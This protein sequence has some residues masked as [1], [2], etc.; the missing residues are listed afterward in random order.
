MRNIVEDGQPSNLP[1]PR[2][3]CTASLTCATSCTAAL[4]TTLLSRY[5]FNAATCSGASPL[6]A[7]RLR[8]NATHTCTYGG[9]SR[10]TS[11]IA[12]STLSEHGTTYVLNTVAVSSLS[13]AALIRDREGST[14]TRRRVTSRSFSPF[15]HRL[16]HRFD[17][18]CSASD[19]CP[20]KASRS[21]S[22]FENVAQ[23]F[24]EM[25]LKL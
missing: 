7:A 24:S 12:S 17:G 1:C 22:F 14:S 19:A 3:S 11:A 6:V 25:L 15:R 10:P 8:K 20:R 4:F 13:S 23:M 18:P 2:L 21:P 5:D 16:S 9:R